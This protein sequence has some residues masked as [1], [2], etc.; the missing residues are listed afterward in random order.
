MYLHAFLYINNDARSLFTYT[1][2][3]KKNIY[4]KDS[5]RGSQEKYYPR[6]SLNLKR[7]AI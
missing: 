7:I 3:E 5:P 6:I 4:I 2:K 1:S